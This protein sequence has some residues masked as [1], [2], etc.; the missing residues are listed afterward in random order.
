MIS[1]I[2]LLTV[3]ELVGWVV[4][5]LTGVTQVV[6]PLWRGTP[7]FPI[8]R[9][10]RKLEGELEEVRQ[11]KIEAD[12]QARIKRERDELEPKERETSTAITDKKVPGAPRRSKQNR[13]GG[14]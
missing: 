11:Q 8:L 7:L 10:E 3:L 2:N 6:I 1:I 14:L 4:L 9:S 12:L 5:M 13:E